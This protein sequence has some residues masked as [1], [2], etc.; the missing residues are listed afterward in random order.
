MQKKGLGLYNQNLESFDY[1][2]QRLNATFH[3]MD[4]YGADEADI[5]GS[6]IK[7][8]FSESLKAL[9]MLQHFWG[10]GHP[11]Q[12]RISAKLINEFTIR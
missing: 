11:F 10:V 12:T 6:S 2:I 9:F 3:I 8:D 4:W 5:N 7:K 1:T